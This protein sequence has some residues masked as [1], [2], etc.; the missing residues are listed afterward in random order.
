MK[1]QKNTPAAMNNNQYTSGGP[2]IST[3]PPTQ[4][5]HDP[6]SFPRSQL[7]FKLCVLN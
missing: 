2:P 4:Q 7:R 1:R 5:F 3:G 6:L